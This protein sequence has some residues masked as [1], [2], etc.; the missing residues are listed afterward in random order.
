M[1]PCDPMLLLLMVVF[2]VMLALIVREFAVRNGLLDGP[3]LFDGGYVGYG[4]VGMVGGSVN[5]GNDAKGNNVSGGNSGCCGGGE[6]DITG[7]VE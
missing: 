1:F 2:I 5:G 6:F 4:A 7:S 3:K